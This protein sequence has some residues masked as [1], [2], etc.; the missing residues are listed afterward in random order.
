MV[1]LLG[2]MGD[3][4]RA[5]MLIINRLG[6]VQRVRSPLSLESEKSSR[7]L[8]SGIK[9]IEF[10]KEQNDDELWEDLLTYSETK[11]RP[12]PSSRSWFPPADHRMRTGFI[13]GLLENV[14]AEI[15]PIRL[16]RR[17]KD[18]LEVPGLKVALIK[19]LQDFNLQVSLMEGC[20]AIMYS[21]V[22]QLALSL[23]DRQTSG[24]LWTGTS[25]FVFSTGTPTN[26]QGT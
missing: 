4:K 11:P 7:K 8:T 15:D 17:I 2:R 20:K 12:S 9:A 16:I 25:R 21:D 14:G 3:N 23:H 1:F 5:L 24:F 26:G 10:A 18:G 19:I 6:D 13:R 22:R